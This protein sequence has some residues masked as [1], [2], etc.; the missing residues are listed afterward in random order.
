VYGTGV[1][2]RFGG[3]YLL[4]ERNEVRAQFAYQ[5]MGA[6][7][8]DLGVAGTADLIATFADYKAYSIEGGYRR[9]FA[10]TR[11]TVRPYAGATLGVTIISEI[12]GVLAAP[13]PGLAQYATDFYDGTAALTFGVN[14]GVLYGLSDR[15]DVGGQV[16]FRYVGG[17]SEI[18]GLAGTGL[19]DTNDKSS[20][21]AMPITFGVRFK[22]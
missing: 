6:D 8:V 21:W 10:D 20:R 15:V 7:L 16:G 13:Q 19:E 4:D 22:F 5:K 12:D 11:E 3:G 9:Y 14:G 17:L 18:D 1:Q 2:W